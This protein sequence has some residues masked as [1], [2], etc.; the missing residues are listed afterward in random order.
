MRL[1]NL[2]RQHYQTDTVKPKIFMSL[3]DFT[4]CSVKH[5]LEG[6]DNVKSIKNKI[7]GKAI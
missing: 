7:I 1:T 3:Y 5:E 2:V 4:E 6:H